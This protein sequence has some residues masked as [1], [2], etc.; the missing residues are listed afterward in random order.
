MLRLRV[1]GGERGWGGGVGEREWRD[2]GEGFGGEEEAGLAWGGG[3]GG[4]GGVKRRRDWGERGA[5]RAGATG[6]LLS[7]TWALVW[8]L[9]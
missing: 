4:L 3:E 6:A 9:A 5:G 7:L 2:W 8:A 1:G